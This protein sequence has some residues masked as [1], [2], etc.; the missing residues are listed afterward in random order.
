MYILFNDYKEIQIYIL[1]D[2]INEINLVFVG[3]I[4]A[5]S[6]NWRY[7]AP[8]SLQLDNDGMLWIKNHDQI[9]VVNPKSTSLDGKIELIA[10][11]NTTSKYINTYN[12]TVIVVEN[13]PPFSLFWKLGGSG[14]FF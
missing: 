9:F 12:Y 5:E 11:I 7:F 3:K 10:I 4:N 8:K 6:L 14:L 2:I 13:E 1:E